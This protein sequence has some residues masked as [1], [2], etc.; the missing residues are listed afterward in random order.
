MIPLISLNRLDDL[1]VRIANTCGPDEIIGTSW[2]A[3][4]VAYMKELTAYWLNEFDWRKTE[5]ESQQ[6]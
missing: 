1:K 2:T 3:V 5:S 4:Q 6:V